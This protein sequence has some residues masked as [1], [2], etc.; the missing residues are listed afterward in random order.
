LW[1]G[2]HGFR[3][4]TAGAGATRPHRYGALDQLSAELRQ[5]REQRDTLD[6]LAEALRTRDG[7]LAYRA[8]A[9]CDQLLEL[10]GQATTRPSAIERIRTALIDRDEA[11]QQA[12]G[13][14]DRAR[15]VAMDWEAEVVSIRTQNWQARA[16]L[17]E[18]R[19][20]QGRAEERAR[21]AEQ[22]A[23]EAEEL[24]AAL[25]AKVAAVA[26]AE[27]QL[28]QERTARQEAEGQLQQER[29]ALADARSVLEREHAALKEA[30]TSLKEREADVSKLDGELITLSI[31]NA[32][33]QR[34]LEEQSA[35][36][37]SLQQAVEAERRALEVE[38]K[39]VEGELPLRLLFC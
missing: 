20:Q 11:L 1:C 28:R 31:S 23:K 6:A 3:L 2:T 17:L 8:V 12:R 33:Q 18:A 16:A 14:L 39:Q 9:L 13:D 29:A 35:T 25:T 36:V 5:L 19:S 15:T 24:K 30:R 7:W 38:K 26:A 37:V 21:E 4:L 34:S 32:D 22:R 27:E 10:E